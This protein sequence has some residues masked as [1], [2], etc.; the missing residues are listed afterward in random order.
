MTLKVFSQNVLFG[1]VAQGRWLDLVAHIRAQEAQFVMLQEVDWLTNRSAVRAAES[2]LDMRLLI[3]KSR[4][5]PTALAWDPKVWTL[6]DSDTD[7][8]DAT[9][10]GFCAGRF[11]LVGEEKLPV[12]L[13]VISAHFNPYSAAFGAIEAQIVG[14]RAYR[15][16]GLGILGGDLNHPPLGD[17]EP[18]WSRIQPYNR[19]GRCLP[20]SG[21][22]DPHRSDTIVGQTLYT[23]D[24]TDVAAYVS[25]QRKDPSLRRPTGRHGGIR[26]DQI[27]VTPG[28][29]PAIVDASRQD[30]G[31]SSDHYGVGGTFDLSRID[32]T[33][34][35][36][37]T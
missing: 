34:L 24:F 36:D 21:P 26:V 5:A 18:D 6:L 4:H 19:M 22:D 12:P 8:Q 33:K 2:D 15:Y 10:H 23:G 29:R 9:W 32:L 30:T 28:L 27:H 35:R 20:R 11:D 13:V 14:T 17:P 31:A 25:D 1:A 3:A 37:Y 7:T 16:G